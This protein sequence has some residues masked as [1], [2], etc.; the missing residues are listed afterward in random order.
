MLVIAF[1]RWESSTLSLPSKKMYDW[2][3]TLTREQTHCSE[4]LQQ[5]PGTWEILP[6]S[7]TSGWQHVPTSRL[8]LSLAGFILLCVDLSCT[9]EGVLYHS[10]WITLQ[11]SSFISKHATFPG[12]N[13]DGAVTGME[14]VSHFLFWQTAYICH[15]NSPHITLLLNLTKGL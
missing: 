1:S 5:K 2:P 3:N 9:G 12:S 11:F 7:E 10:K 15:L 13:R 4:T 14:T 8:C 6:K